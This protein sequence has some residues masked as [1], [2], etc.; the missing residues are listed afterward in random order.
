VEGHS[1]K[2]LVAAAE[3]DIDRVLKGP[4]LSRTEEIAK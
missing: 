1:R 4:G 2:N 3:G